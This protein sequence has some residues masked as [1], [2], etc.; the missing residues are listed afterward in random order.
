[1]K[2]STLRSC[3]F[4]AALMVVVL[5]SVHCATIINGTSQAVSVN[6][7]PMQATVVINQTG[8]GRVFEGTTPATCKLSRK[9]DYDVVVTM[10]GYKQ[11]TVHISQSFSPVYFGNCLIG[12]V[13]GMIC[14]LIT[15]AYNDW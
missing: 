13:P 11:E 9:S 12:G 7:E 2:P 15:G 6:S 14:D 4:K 5:A 8:G 10:S 3:M 1:M